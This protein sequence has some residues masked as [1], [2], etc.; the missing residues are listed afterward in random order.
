MLPC[1]LT[2]ELLEGYIEDHGVLNNSHLLLL[3]HC[4]HSLLE[5]K[6]Y[7]V[8]CLTTPKSI[9]LLYRTLSTSPS[10]ASMVRALFVRGGSNDTSFP[11]TLDPLLPR[12]AYT[13]QA[14]K[15]IKPQH[16]MGLS[17]LISK[18]AKTLEIL[19]LKQIEPTPVARGILFV[20]DFP[21]LSTLECP[22][23]LVSPTLR[24]PSCALNGVCLYCHTT[25][26]EHPTEK[27]AWMANLTRLVVALDKSH[28]NGSPPCIAH[29]S[30]LREY[31]L[32]FVGF[33][34]DVKP[35]QAATLGAFA[36]MPSSVSVVLLH[37]NDPTLTR[38]SIARGCLHRP[39]I[40][41]KLCFVFNGSTA[42]NNVRSGTVTIARPLVLQW[43]I[44][45]EATREE[46]IWENAS[47]LI[48]SR[49]F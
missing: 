27:F 33:A 32:D 28:S 6:F 23:A 7:R 44:E 5:K 20:H 48:I 35:I 16:H 8:V 41:R 47:D 9:S 25:G 11:W 18:V 29:F 15:A 14:T 2:L 43:A 13:Q 10:K 46:D 24:P 26:E 4:T 34:R 19:V 42:Q 17:L 31:A 38:M 3:N 21:M 36:H 49:V 39:D 40:Y 22:A 37:E 45:L 30:S 12:Y 1:F